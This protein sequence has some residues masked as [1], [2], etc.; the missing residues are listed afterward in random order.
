[1]LLDVLRAASVLLCFVSGGVLLVRA[2][3]AEQTRAPERPA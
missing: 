1:M 3:R 2:A